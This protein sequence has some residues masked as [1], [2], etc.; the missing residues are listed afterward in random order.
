MSKVSSSSSLFDYV[1]V[2]VMFI[3][4]LNIM[5]QLNCL[6][7]YQSIHIHFVVVLVYDS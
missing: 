5:L 1:V 3:I 6:V 4:M 7:S 2:V